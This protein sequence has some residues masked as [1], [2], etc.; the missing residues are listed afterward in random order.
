MRRI[1]GQ[2]LLGVMLGSC[3]PPL[4]VRIWQIV[5]L[6]PDEASIQKDV[7]Q[8]DGILK[9]MKFS[10]RPERSNPCLVEGKENPFT[11]WTSYGRENGARNI[12]GSLWVRRQTRIIEFRFVTQSD[13]FTAWRGDIGAISE[14]DERLKEAFAG[15]VVSFDG[16]ER[17]ICDE[18]KS[19]YE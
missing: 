8:I 2:L 4:T 18:M 9:S 12:W 14:M 6:Q 17:R 1:L 11:S 3:T 7:A 13:G 15:R 10:G 5:P 19:R 16:R